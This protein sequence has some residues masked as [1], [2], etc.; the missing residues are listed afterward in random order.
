MEIQLWKQT[1]I[2]GLA[3][4]CRVTFTYVAA[5]AITEVASYIKTWFYN[6]VVLVKTLV[7]VICYWKVHYKVHI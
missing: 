7:L 1:A 4:A 3:A 2:D 6:I 5:P